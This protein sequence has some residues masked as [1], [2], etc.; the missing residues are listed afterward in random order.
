MAE[1]ITDVLSVIPAN[2]WFFGDRFEGK[3]PDLDPVVVLAVVAVIN[4]EH[5]NFG[6]HKAIIPLG[7]DDYS[8]LYFIIGKE[9]KTLQEDIV[10]LNQLEDTST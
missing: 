8:D 2:N 4:N 9:L 3:S 5:P 6:S 7:I 10:H 1:Y